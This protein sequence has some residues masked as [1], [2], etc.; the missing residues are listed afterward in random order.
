MISSINAP[1]APPLEEFPIGD[2]ELYEWEKNEIREIDIEDKKDRYFKIPII[3]KSGNGF[4]YAH[5]KGPYVT[6]QIN[7][8]TNQ[9]AEYIQEGK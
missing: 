8:Y 7:N 9:D 3:G 1:S 2:D 4:W 5:F 6:R